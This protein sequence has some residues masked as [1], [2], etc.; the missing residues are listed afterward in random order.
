MRYPAPLVIALLLSEIFAEPSKLTPAIVRAVANVVAV[1][2]R[3]TAIFADPSKEVPPIVLAVDKVVAVD[4]A[5]PRTSKSD[6]VSTD[7]SDWNISLKK[8][9]DSGA[10]A[11]IMSSKAGEAEGVSVIID[12]PC[13]GRP[14]LFAGFM[15]KKCTVVMLCVVHLTKTTR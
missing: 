4:D 2:A 12:R 7:N 6:F 10:G 9:G 1:A 8:A 11:Q 15:S 13:I 14:A 5:I 3:A